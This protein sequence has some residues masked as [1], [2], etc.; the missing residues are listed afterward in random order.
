VFFGLIIAL[1]TAKYCISPH[2][3]HNQSVFAIVCMC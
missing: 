3:V 2:A 1:L